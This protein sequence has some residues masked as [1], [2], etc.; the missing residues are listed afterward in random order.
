MES[1]LNSGESNAFLSL[2]LPIRNLADYS[3]QVFHGPRFAELGNVE[4]FAKV[5]AVYPFGGRWRAEVEDRLRGRQPQVACYLGEDWSF[6]EISQA[7]WICRHHRFSGLKSPNHTVTVGRAILDIEGSLFRIHPDLRTSA[8]AD[9][10]RST[11]VKEHLAEFCKR[12]VT[13]ACDGNCLQAPRAEDELQAVLDVVVGQLDSYAAEI[14]LNAD[15][16][17]EQLLPGAQG[18]MG[19]G[20]GFSSQG[21]AEGAMADTLDPFRLPDGMQSAGDPV[22]GNPFPENAPQHQVWNDA[23]RRAEEEHC[24]FNSRLLKERPS[25]G[26]GNNYADWMIGMAV[27][28]FDIWA[29]R[30]VHVVWSDNEVGAYDQWLFNYAQGWLELA[31][32][33]SPILVHVESLLNELRLRLMERMGYWK[34]EG[35]RYVAEQKAAVETASVQPSPATGAKNSGDLRKQ[36]GRPQTIPDEKK[37]AAASLKASGG[38]NNQV[39]QVLYSTK[40]PTPQQVKNVSSHLRAYAA[41]L[42]KSASPALAI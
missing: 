20:V 34:A 9:F 24:R 18:P 6:R 22:E 27:E 15:K 37:A 23:T 21:I 11:Q 30:G 13:S 32:K 28:K 31:R 3:G 7:A 35:R 38:T 5:P 8:V 4:Q 41:K 39:A 16:I 42:N 17:E 40:R 1:F 25:R 2:R 12:V 19:G 33:T 29:K 36:R 26:L 10:W 14:M